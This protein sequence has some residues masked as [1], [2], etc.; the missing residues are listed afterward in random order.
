MEKT[1]HLSDCCN[2]DPAI[3]EMILDVLSYGI[4]KKIVRSAL[5]SLK[6]AEEA[7]YR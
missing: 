2:L 6:S 4:A 5:E 3:L 7:I 1:N